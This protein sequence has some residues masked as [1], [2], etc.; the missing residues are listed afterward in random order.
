MKLNQFIATSSLAAIALFNVVQ[1]HGAEAK[2]VTITRGSHGAAFIVK[3]DRVPVDAKVL[4]SQIRQ[5]AQQQNV[6][7]SEQFKT[8]SLL[9]RGP[10]GAFFPSS[11]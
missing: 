4:P 8:S 3:A 1:A 11:R 6:G 5:E 7:G 9:Q 2:T 10:R